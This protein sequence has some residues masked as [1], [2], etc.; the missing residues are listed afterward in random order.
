MTSPRSCNSRVSA[1]NRVKHAQPR[2]QNPRIMSRRETS[3]Y[4]TAGAYPGSGR[5]G[6]ERCADSSVETHR[7]RSL[8]CLDVSDVNLVCRDCGC[9]FTFTEAEQEYFRTQR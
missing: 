3:W 5:E 2:K 4:G 6:E 8:G 9:D 1:L 7:G